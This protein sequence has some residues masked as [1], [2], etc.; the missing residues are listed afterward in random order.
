MA[1]SDRALYWIAYLPGLALSVT[2]VIVTG[3]IWGPIAGA[4]VAFVAL[5]SLFFSCLFCFVVM[6]KYRPVAKG[7]SLALGVSLYLAGIGIALLFLY[8]FGPTQIM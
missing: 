7:H 5:P 1:A 2:A 4:L 3:L 6:L 8:L